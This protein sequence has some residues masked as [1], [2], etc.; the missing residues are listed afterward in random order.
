MVIVSV[1][2]LILFLLYYFGITFDIVYSNGYN[3]LIVWYYDNSNP[4]KRTYKILMRL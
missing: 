1:I 2:L 3:Y 4:Y